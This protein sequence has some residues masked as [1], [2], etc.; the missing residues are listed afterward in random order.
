MN[1][2]DI[3]D[4]PPAEWQLQ[5]ISDYFDWSE[6]VVAGLRGVSKKLE[7]LFD[8]TVVKGRA[9]YGLDQVQFKRMMT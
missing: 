5:R 2:R 9:K 3:C 4:N 8:E 6:N 7:D 1:L